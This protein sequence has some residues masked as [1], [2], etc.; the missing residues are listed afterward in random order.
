MHV[1]DKTIVDNHEAWLREAHAPA[2]ARRTAER[3]AAF[4]L[5]HLKPGMR[6]I[7]AG[8]GA[9]S[10][11]LGLAT[12]I[13]PGETAGIDLSHVS[14][15]RARALAAER[16]IDNCLFETADARALPFAD[17]TFD[18]A[19]A[20]ALLQHVEFPLDALREL[21]RVLRPGGVIGIADAD[22]DGAIMAP[23]F[24]AL[25]LWHDIQ[26]RQPRHPNIGRHLRALLHEAGFERV[27]A[28]AVAS[29]R[30]DAIS[31]K[32]DGEACARYAESEPFI[33]Y[34]VANGWATREQMLEIAAAWRAWGEDPGAFFAAF[35][36]QAVAWAPA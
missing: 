14:I 24:D 18:A 35:W 32:L 27:Q 2:H 31:V 6:L 20:H 30:G 19:F 4:L 29:A 22:R 21:R 36:C 3:N 26:R 28:S 34:A 12:A 10:I 7:D 1:M 15:D 13:A 17:A 16:G 23:D 25:R 5:P 11:T 9:G 33:A 8:C